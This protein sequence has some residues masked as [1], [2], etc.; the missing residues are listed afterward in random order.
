MAEVIQ[1]PAHD[2][3]DWSKVESLMRKEM[4]EA[5][6]PEVVINEVLSWL[7]DLWFKLREQ[8]IHYQ[9][10][11]PGVCNEP[12]DEA[13]HAVIDQMRDKLYLTLIEAAGQKTRL[14]MLKYRHSSSTE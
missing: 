7:K 8:P 4:A 5:E 9:I 13:V 10:K 11:A 2:E 14:E 12:I 1:F 3:R 6:A